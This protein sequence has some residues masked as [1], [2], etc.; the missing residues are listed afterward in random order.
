MGM[1]G[2]GLFWFFWLI[3]CMMELID[4]LG[5]SEV[6]RPSLS[7]S[8]G[9]SRKKKKTQIRWLEGESEGKGRETTCELCLGH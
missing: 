2:W 3:E 1:D 4:E 9:P 5:V 6:S 8:F 7:L